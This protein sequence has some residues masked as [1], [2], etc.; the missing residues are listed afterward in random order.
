VSAEPIEIPR[1]RVEQSI[2]MP[3]A[4]LRNRGRLYVALDGAVAAYITLLACG[5][6]QVLLDWGLRLTAEQRAFVSAIAVVISLWTVRRRL[7][8]PLSRALSDKTLALVVDRAFPKMHDRI[9][10][11]VQFARGQCGPA[12]SNSPQL[13][14][15]IISEACEA[16]PSVEFMSVLNHR[17]AR[18][19]T[20]E[21]AGLLSATVIAAAVMPDMAGAWFRRN[22]LF[23]ET[24]WP[25]R[26]YIT[27]IGFDDD[28][29]C[30]APR[31]EELII[32]ARNRGRVPASVEL[33]WTTDSNLEGVETMTRVGIDRWRASLGVL[34]ENLAFRIAGGDERTREYVVQPADRPRVIHTST[35]ISPPAYTGMEMYSLERQTVLEMLKGSRVEIEATFNRP[36]TD[37]R[38]VGGAGEVVA[39]MSAAPDRA[40]VT[41]DAP[42]AGK[43]HFELVDRDGWTNRRPVIFTFDVE[44]D[45]A[46]VVSLTLSDA[47]GNITPT[48]ELPLDID[49]QDV[50]G[51]ASA[52]LYI[53]RNDDPPHEIT[54]DDFELGSHDFDTHY[55]FDVSRIVVEPGDRLRLWL[56]ACDQDPAG[57]NTGRCNPI[58]L[59]A[60]TPAD[61]LNELAARE[62]ELR[63]EFERLISTQRGLADA[64]NRLAPTL[65]VDGAPTPAISQRLAALARLQDSN[66][67]SCMSISRRFERMLG[68]MRVN[69]VSRIG[70]ERRIGQR[71]IEPL[72]KLAAE[73]MPESSGAVTSLRTEVNR[74]VVAATPR[75]QSEILRK[76]SAILANMLE[77]EGYRE[78]VA[79]L[80]ELRGEQATL[81]DDTIKRIEREL[82]AILG[83]DEIPELGSDRIPSP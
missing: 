60:V 48:A 46:P 1:A 9:A 49:C 30:R 61:F 57:P 38:F 5:A 3:L 34:N 80:R 25:Q 68:E 13:V 55:F 37:V 11:A 75:W 62:M 18:R 65:P 79:L 54:F 6:A 2:F 21:L 69:K 63:R 15:A 66:A 77:W 28:G 35:R 36:I 27:P 43:Y 7:W 16:A 73:D 78:A 4:R 58:I 29:A 17:R 22:W 33:I 40:Y 59:R 47:G 71:V 14:G 8:I 82:E 52:T 83:L 26:T 41:W 70:D 74:D 56:E 10:A 51:L 44:P 76:M 24:P 39:C 81:H 31:G 32:T 19:R 42:I 45:S 23:Q 64:L 72:R 53:R 67:Q 20:G 50:Y 12:E